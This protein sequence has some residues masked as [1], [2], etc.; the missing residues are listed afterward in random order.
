MSGSTGKEDSLDG[1]FAV[2]AGGVCFSIDVE[3]VFESA[4][5]AVGVLEISEGRAAGGDGFFEDSSDG[6][7]KFR[8]AGVFEQG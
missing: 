2:W 3:P 4:D 6:V 5:V 8:G 1:G 7:E